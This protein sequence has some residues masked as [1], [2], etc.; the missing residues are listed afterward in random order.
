MRFTVGK[1]LATGF[2]LIIVLIVTLYVFNNRAAVR[3]AE[4]VRIATEMSEYAGLLAAKQLDHYRWIEQLK[5]TFSENLPAVEA[6]L[7][8]HECGLGQW[9]DSPEVAQLTRLDAQAGAMIEKLRASHQRL[10]AS[11]AAID[12]EWQQHHPGLQHA[13]TGL[14]KKHQ[15]WVIKVASAMIHGDRVLKVKTDPA[16]CALGTYLK[17]EQGQAYLAT[18]P[19][20]AEAMR[21]IEQP[22]IAFHTSAVHINEALAAGEDDRARQIFKDETLTALA[23]VSGLFDVIVKEEQD[24][25]DAQVRAREILETRAQAAVAEVQATLKELSKH[26]DART[27]SLNA[28]ARAEMASMRTMSLVMTALVVALSIVAG[29]FITR[30]ITKPVRTLLAGFEE[31]EQGDLTV[32]I[33]SGS[34]DEL[35]DLTRG[36]TKLVRTLREVLVQVATASTE[37]A[38]AATEIAASSEQMARGIDQQSEQASQ[39]LSAV[40][41]MTAVVTEVAHK[42]EQAAAASDDAGE[43]AV[44]GSDVVEKTVQEINVIAGIVDDS[45][46]AIAELGRQA[47]QI[48]GIISVINDIADQTNLLALNAAIEAARAGEHGRGFAVVADEVRKLAE[49]TTH[50]TTEVSESIRSIQGQT[51]TAVEGMDA[52]TQRVRD[53]VTLAQEAG[54][55][56]GLIVTGAR[57]VSN[58]VRSIAS[59]AA[60]QSAATEEIARRVEAIASVTRE[61]AD[62]AS[63]AA[64]AAAQLSAKSE[65]LLDLV[66]RFKLE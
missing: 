17:S 11:A 38:G 49:R 35:G 31:V 21:D 23:Q 22:H 7:D 20:F 37:V 42:S 45:S 65:Q 62:G 57:S 50:A 43:Q 9:L 18:Y 40:E 61:S 5:A 24:R 19:K 14:R 1:K 2:A 30:S 52:G 41:E 39:V 54:S 44:S 10:H 53:G 58:E 25:I 59:A 26:L 63:Q 16:T 47:E 60:E 55:A 32:S 28:D 13:L 4:K 12:S 27:A 64:A 56:L 48:D 46:A 36:F 33:E 3:A 6:Q 66:R 8:E 15:G 34:K 51:G 29:F